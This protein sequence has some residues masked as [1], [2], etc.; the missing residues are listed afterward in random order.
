MRNRLAREHKAI[1]ESRARLSAVKQVAASRVNIVSSR[2]V[3]E[4]IPCRDIGSS[5]EIRL[6]SL[7]VTSEHVSKARRRA[8]AEARLVVSPKRATVVRPSL[9]ASS[10]L[11][12]S[13][14]LR[15]QNTSHTDAQKCGDSLWDTSPNVHLTPAT[16]SPTFNARALAASKDGSVP[17]GGPRGGV[18]Q[19]GSVALVYQQTHSENV[20]LSRALA[21]PQSAAARKGSAAAASPSSSSSKRKGT[22]QQAE[23][24]ASVMAV[25]PQPTSKERVGLSSAMAEKSSSLLVPTG[26][27]AAATTSRKS[28]Q[29]SVPHGAAVIPGPA[30]GQLR[31]MPF[32]VECGQR[33]IDDLAKF[34]ALCGHKRAFL[35]W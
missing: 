34:C 3:E 20:F 17:G 14:Q 6:S 32:C 30:T 24:K 11:H 8:S 33:H 26:S 25:A 4:S 19:T 16:F 29:L 31:A 21:H 15:R 27:A 1:E 18:S 9:A 23:S 10:V 7:Q 12:D 2:G 13:Q 22:L 28:P 5:L 35:P